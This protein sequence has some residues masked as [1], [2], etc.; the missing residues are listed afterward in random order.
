MTD[1]MQE[2][3]NL[4]REQ[5]DLAATQRDRSVYISLSTVGINISVDPWPEAHHDH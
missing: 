3:I 5:I 1:E 2:M 4:A